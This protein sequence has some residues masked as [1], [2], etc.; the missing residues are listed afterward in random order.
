[1]I[2]FGYSFGSAVRLVVTNS[3]DATVWHCYQVNITFVARIYR[4]YYAIHGSLYTSANVLITLC[5][6]EQQVNTMLSVPPRG[7]PWVK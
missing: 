1:M 2:I 3:N 6:Y 7:D 4:N 5:M